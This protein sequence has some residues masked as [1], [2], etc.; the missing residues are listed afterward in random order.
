MFFHRL[1]VLQKFIKGE[2]SAIKVFKLAMNRT[3]EG[4]RE[5]FDYIS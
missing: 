5:G 3:V 4:L 2:P 1:K